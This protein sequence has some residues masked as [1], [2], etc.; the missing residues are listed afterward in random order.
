MIRSFV[1]AGND[2]TKAEHIHQALHYG[3]GLKKNKSGVAEIEDFNLN[4]VKIPLISNYHS[5]EFFTDHMTLMRYYNVGAGV[6]Q[7]YLYIKPEP[8]VNM[9]IPYSSTALDRL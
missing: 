5:I 6:Q 9:V 3:N 4:G 7:K 8:K 2:V 1:D